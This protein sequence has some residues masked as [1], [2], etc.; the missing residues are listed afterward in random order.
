MRLS[1]GYVSAADEVEILTRLNRTHPLDAVV[2]CARAGALRAVP[3]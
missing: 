1:L 2:P 3:R